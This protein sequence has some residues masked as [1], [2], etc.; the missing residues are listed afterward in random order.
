MEVGWEEAGQQD[1]W[2]LAVG[3]RRAT[4]NGGWGM[5]S[6]S[7]AHP[8][9][10]GPRMGERRGESDSLSRATSRGRVAPGHEARSLGCVSWF[11]PSLD[12]QAS[13]LPPLPSAPHLYWGWVI[14]PASALIGERKRVC[15]L[16]ALGGVGPTQRAP[17]AITWR[18]IWTRSWRTFSIKDR[19]SASHMVSTAYSFCSFQPSGNVKAVLKSRSLQKQTT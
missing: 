8:H 5:G 19:G 9:D 12:A 10:E 1:T 15:V 4:T 17:L 18:T 11:C 14:T 7:D 6:I 16:T 3:Q 2:S 13:K